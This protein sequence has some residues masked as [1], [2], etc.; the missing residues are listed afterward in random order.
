[1]TDSPSTNWDALKEAARKAD[2]HLSV[3]GAIREASL[4]SHAL[5]ESL[6]T[7][8]NAVENKARATELSV[9]DLLRKR[10][11]DQERADKLAD[12]VG[13]I[14]D[15]TT[16]LETG[17][18]NMHDRLENLEAT[19][20]VEDCD[21]A[22]ELFAAKIK[23]Q[24]LRERVEKYTKENGELL[25]RLGRANATIDK[26]AARLANVR[27]VARYQHGLTYKHHLGTVRN[28]LGMSIDGKRQ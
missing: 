27:H 26:Q 25:E 28:A 11:E 5:I 18:G 9:S 15:R 4:N 2:S 10:K 23:I 13:S 16:C 12:W 3:L 14:A 7:R 22:Q 17:A 6:A 8:L 21:Q 20:E 1:M 19:Q 24:S